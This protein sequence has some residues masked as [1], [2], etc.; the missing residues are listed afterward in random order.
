MAVSE[1]SET[2][3]TFHKVEMLYATAKVANTYNSFTEIKLRKGAKTILGFY[4]VVIDAKPTDGQNA[5]CTIKIESKDLKLHGI[6]IASG[7][8][9]P[10]GDLATGTSN[11]R[12]VWHDWSPDLSGFDNIDNAG[13]TFSI[14]PITNKTEG[15]AAGIELVYTDATTIPEEVKQHFLNGTIET[16]YD[17]DF[18]R[19]AAGVGTGTTYA[20]WGTDL[21]DVIRL[22]SQAKRLV[23]VFAETVPNAFTTVE[24]L[25]AAYRF[26]CSSIDLEPFEILCGT[27]WDAP[28][29]TVISVAMAG[30][31]RYLPCY[32]ALGVGV[33]DVTIA[34]KAAQAVS[35]EAEGLSA[36]AWN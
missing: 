26:T 21:L 17:G 27:A 9:I 14:A 7:G 19:E 33:V 10:D 36:W 4:E 22:T 3:Q 31:G 11:H 1:I 8:L 23:G 2:F 16:F 32:K 25:L 24:G 29:G 20:E 15:V 13:I 6:L 5:M 34:D 30:Q 18:G 35:N 28:L 12:K